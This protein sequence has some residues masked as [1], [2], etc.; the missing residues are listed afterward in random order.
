MMKP[1]LFLHEFH[2]KFSVLLTGMA[3]CGVMNVAQSQ[4]D[5]GAAKAENPPNRTPAQLVQNMTPEQRRALMQGRIVERLQESRADMIRQSLTQGGFDDKAT[6]DAVVD[7]ANEQIKAAVAMR[8]KSTKV[9]EAVTDKTTTDAQ[10][11]VLLNDLHM[12]QDDEKTRRETAEKALDAKIS[13]TK[14]PRLEAVLTTLNLIG[15]GS[16]LLGGMGQM[17]GG[18][19]MMALG[20]A[21]GFGGGF[22]GL[23]GRAAGNNPF[24]N[25]AAGNGVLGRGGRG[26][27]GAFDGGFGGRGAGGNAAGNQ[28]DGFNLPRDRAERIWRREQRNAPANNAPANQDGADKKENAAT[29]AKTQA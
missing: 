12:A 27:G 9:S 24:G 7:F 11:S 14:K 29:E 4:P 3:L 13:Y 22:G 15:D 2:T 5:L 26:F 8:E 25:N 20:G 16:N 23:G 1:T 19:G 28:A 17:N 6:Q 18:R 10:I 21:G